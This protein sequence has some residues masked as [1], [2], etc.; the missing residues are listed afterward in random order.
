VA[1]SLAT[2]SL[3]IAFLFSLVLMPESA[4]S[5]SLA[6]DLFRSTGGLDETIF[7]ILEMGD[8]ANIFRAGAGRQIK[9]VRKKMN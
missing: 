2:F 9:G 7:A 1:V 5:P 4:A 3:I 6:L 8:F